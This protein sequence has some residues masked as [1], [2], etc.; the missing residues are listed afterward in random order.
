MNTQ[1]PNTRVHDPKGNHGW[2]VV[3][4]SGWNRH[5]TADSLEQREDL[6]EV[7]AGYAVI[8]APVS[9][10]KPFGIRCA[11]V[12]VLPR[13][14]E[15]VDGQWYDDGADGEPWPW[16]RDASELDAEKLHSVAED[17]QDSDASEFFIERMRKAIREIETTP[18]I[19]P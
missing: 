14:E 11:L 10:E 17:Q 18:K 15:L 5:A 7:P 8:V 1:E 19:H 9:R 6:P 16:A 13:H 4:G 12:R 2:I 3:N